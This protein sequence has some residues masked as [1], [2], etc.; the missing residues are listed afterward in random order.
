MKGKINFSFAEKIIEKRMGLLR[1]NPDIADTVINRH[2]ANNPAHKLETRR[3]IFTNDETRRDFLEKVT[4]RLHS[5]VEHNKLFR[6]NSG[7][8]FDKNIGR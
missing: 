6:Q 2:I 1:D 7:L 3:D 8:G 4:N 5:S